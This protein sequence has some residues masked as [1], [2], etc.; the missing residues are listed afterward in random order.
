MGEDGLISRAKRVKEEQ[1][2]AEITDKLELEKGTLYVNEQG[3]TPVGT[4][5]EHIKN[6][7]IIEQEDI[8]TISEESS[9]ITVEGKYVFLVEK[10]EN[11]NIKIKYLGTVEN[12]IL[13]EATIILN[14]TATDI[15]NSITATV[16]HID[17]QIGIN[18]NNC[19]YVYNTTASEIGTNQASYK[20]GTFSS[21]PQTIS[22]STT[23][24][25]TYYLH[26]LSVDNVGNKKETISNA[27]TVQVSLSNLKGGDYVKYDT[28]V[29]SIG[30]NGVINCRVLYEKD[31][32]KG[33]GLQIISTVSLGIVNLSG[34]NA[35]NNAITTLNNTA[36]TYLNTT[37]ATDVRCV[38][39]NPTN[40]NAEN[41]S[42]LGLNGINTGCKGPDSNYLEDY[43]RLQEL[44]MIN[45]FSHYFM[46]SRSCGNVSGDIYHISIRYV[47]DSILDSINGNIVNV[48]GKDVIDC[49]HGSNVLGCFT[50]KDTL[51]VISGDG[52]TPDTAYVLSA[53]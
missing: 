13:S 25:G 10:E 47:Y 1:K 16:T 2:I 19:K 22:L 6:K 44:S 49:S 20:G 48:R 27:L 5:L 23:T 24:S 4:Y 28:G 43:N 31:N 38:G 39:S 11:K 41:T 26:V 36:R 7:G 42:S 17:N 40:K 29:S 53:N 9:N 37:Y 12:I 35:Y 21:N 3:P 52:K 46:A 45:I 8:K 14:S 50:I 34:R 15:E 51:K 32:A 30:T 33:Y 18:I